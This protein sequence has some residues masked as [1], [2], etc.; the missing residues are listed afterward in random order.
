MITELEYISVDRDSESEGRT[1]TRTMMNGAACSSGSARLTPCRSP[2]PPSDIRSH[3][4][5]RDA[6]G[7]SESVTAGHG[8]GL[9]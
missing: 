9:P 2:W 4:G 7:S 6:G 8:Q 5:H 1:G 3:I